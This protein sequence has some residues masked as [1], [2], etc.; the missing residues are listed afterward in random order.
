MRAI[1]PDGSIKEYGDAGVAA[2][3]PS[4]TALKQQMRP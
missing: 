2:L 3:D 1:H 4:G